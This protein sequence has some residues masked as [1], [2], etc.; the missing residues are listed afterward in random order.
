MEPPNWII[1]FIM[2]IITD[3]IYTMTIKFISQNKKCGAIIGN[4][5]ISL[6][7]LVSTWIVIN[8]Q[9]WIDILAFITGCGIGT[10][11]VMSYKERKKK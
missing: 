8:D 9:S 4:M 2:G 11:T 6:I 1:L 3:I 7:G 10:Y 5:L